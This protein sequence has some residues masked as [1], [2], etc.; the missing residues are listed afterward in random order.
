MRVDRLQTV[1][2]TPQGCI[3]LGKDKTSR[4]TRSG[5]LETLQA[6]GATAASWTDG[7]LLLAE[8]QRVRVMRD[9]KTIAEQ[10]VN[11]RVTALTMVGGELVL[12]YKDGSIERHTD[13][14]VM[15]FEGTPASPVQR[16]IHGP[17]S[18]VIAGYG[19]GMV[20]MWNATTG[21]RL[22]AQYLHGQ[23]RHVIQVDHVVYIASDLGQHLRWDLDAFYLSHCELLE[24]V[25]KR[26][27]ITW[28]DGRAVEAPPPDG[29]CP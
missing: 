18:T 4:L 23:V 17:G 12:A 11:A 8:H 21:K 1:L 6:G 29:E 3:A 5:Q 9:Q 20:A 19:G 14:G 24:A 28:R 10:A 2:A 26:V 16:L 7:K 25:R 15:T 13:E 27:P 22:A